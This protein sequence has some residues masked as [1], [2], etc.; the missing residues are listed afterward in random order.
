MIHEISFFPPCEHASL[1][2]E[3]DCNVYDDD[4]H[5]DKSHQHIETNEILSSEAAEGEKCKNNKTLDHDN[6]RDGCT[7]RRV[8]PLARIWDDD[9]E[10]QRL[11]SLLG[12]VP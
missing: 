6:E 7:D 2:L 11:Q 1:L 5:P 10:Y 12:I 3:V 4:V 8:S 9:I